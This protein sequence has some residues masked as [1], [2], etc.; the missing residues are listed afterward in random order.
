ML[1]YSENN[2]HFVTPILKTEGLAIGYRTKKGA[3]ILEENLDIHI[4]NGEMVCLI[5]PNGCGKSTLMR[6]LAGLQ[7]PICGVSFISGVNLKKISPHKCA[8]LLSLV[9]TDK[10]EAGTMTVEEIVSIG[11]YPYINYF[12]KLRSQDEWIIHESLEKV[13]LGSYAKRCFSELSDGEK[14]RVMIAKAL[15]QDTPLIMLDEPTAHLDLPNRV[16]IMNLLKQLA[17]EV[18]KGILLS[19][20]ELDLALQTADTIW[21]MHRESKLIKGTPEDLV[22]RGSFENVFR[23]NAFDFDKYTGSF[24]VKHQSK[25]EISLSGDQGVPFLWTK[26]ALERDGYRVKHQ[27]TSPVQ[28]QLINDNEWRVALH[29][30]EIVCK[31]IADVLMTLHH[32]EWYRKQGK[33]IN[34]KDHQPVSCN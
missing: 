4:R 18:N 32:Q 31:S 27:N 26:R 15:A 12:A 23:G 11:R 21:L 29:D 5:G 1:N 14:Q 16:E 2:H 19:T 30:Q 28:V 33:T 24:K 34:C 6:T 13:H 25:G 7:N 10:I 9:L 3:T 20:H 22:I 8:K 17:K